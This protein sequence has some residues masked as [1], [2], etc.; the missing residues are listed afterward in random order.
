MLTKD[1]PEIVA[2][3]K[4]HGDKVMLIQRNAP[5]HS[6]EFQVHDFGREG[7]TLICAALVTV[8]IA[9]GMRKMKVGDMLSCRA[10]DADDVARMWTTVG[11]SGAVQ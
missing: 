8:E 7:N 6:F 3:C 4:A 9:E 5:G 11:R 1:D 10:V 2:A